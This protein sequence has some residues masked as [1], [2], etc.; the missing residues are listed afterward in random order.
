MP[1][2]EIVDEED[3]WRYCGG[4][5]GATELPRRTRPAV[6]RHRMLNLPPLRPPA[7]LNRDPTDGPRST[8][9]RRRL[10][11]SARSVAAALRDDPATSH[12]KPVHGSGYRICHL[13]ASSTATSGQQ[14]SRIL[15]GHRMIAAQRRHSLVIPARPRS[16]SMARRMLRLRSLGQRSL[17]YQ[18]ASGSSSSKVRHDDRATLDNLH[19]Q[20][21]RERSARAAVILGDPEPTDPQLA[22]GIDTAH[23]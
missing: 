6:N 22:F 4:V 12:R 13:R 11:R 20:A 21:A 10:L 23:P 5:D 1:W 8:V 9:P 16:R 3:T 2:R 17:A 14:V 18:R 15:G 7:T 19:H